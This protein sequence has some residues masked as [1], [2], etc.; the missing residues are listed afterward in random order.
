MLEKLEAR[1]T[2]EEENSYYLCKTC[3]AATFNEVMELDFACPRCTQPVEH[4]DNEALLSALKRR[5]SAIRECLGYEW[6]PRGH[7]PGGEPT[8]RRPGGEVGAAPRPCRLR[9]TCHRP[10]EGGNGTGS[11]VYGQPRSKPGSRPCGGN[12][13]RHRQGRDARDRPCPAG[14]CPGEVPRPR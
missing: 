8:G 1:E 14:R 2:F 11:P 7:R 12:A 13:S 9:E 3:G 4:F 10:R 5:I 6:S